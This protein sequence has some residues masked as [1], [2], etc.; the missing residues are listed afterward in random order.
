[1][2]SVQSS[3]RG[4]CR[5]SAEGGFESPKGLPHPYLRPV[6]GQNNPRGQL[7]FEENQ[8]HFKTNLTECPTIHDHTQPKGFV[9]PPHCTNPTAYDSPF[10]N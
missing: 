1:M 3:I 2:I 5:I 10:N 6:S 9:H 4:L 7:P 8:N